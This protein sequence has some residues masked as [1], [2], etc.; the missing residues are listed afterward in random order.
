M[1]AEIAV[2]AQAPGEAYM[3]PAGRSRAGCSRLGLLR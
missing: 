2:T 1:A 3:A